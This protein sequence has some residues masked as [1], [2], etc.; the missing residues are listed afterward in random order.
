MIQIELKN[1]ERYEVN[2]V[3]ENYTPAGGDN[4]ARHTLNIDFGR[5]T[6]SGIELETLAASFTEEQIS[7]IHVY[8][9]GELIATF[10]GYTSP[11]FAKTIGSQ[12][13]MFRVMASK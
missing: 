7:L 8:D 2:T 6:A 1:N 11:C 12:G 3:S 9:E 4:A 13:L 5:K 10:T